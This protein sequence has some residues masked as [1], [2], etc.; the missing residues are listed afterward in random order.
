MNMPHYLRCQNIRTLIEL[1]TL[2]NAENVKNYLYA[3]E[4]QQ[5][6]RSY[7]TG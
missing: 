3:K 5:M 1:N 4:R 6:H 2:K 7:V